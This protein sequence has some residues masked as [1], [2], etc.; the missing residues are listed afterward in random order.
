[1]SAHAMRTHGTADCLRAFDQ[2]GRIRGDA[3]LGQFRRP[4]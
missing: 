3:Y 1:V 4:S 2:S